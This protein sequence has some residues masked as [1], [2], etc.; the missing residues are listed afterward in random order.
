MESFLSRYRN[1]LILVA[2]LFAQVLGLAVQVRRPADSEHPDRGSVRLIRT[3]AVSAISP[4]EKVLVHSGRLVRGLWTDYV[5]LR[6]VREQNET[7]R[8]QIGR[9]RIEEVRL[10]E[11]AAQA[12]RLQTL[13]DFRSQFITGTLPAQVIG[14]S[15]SRVSRVIY[16]DKGSGDG[17]EKDMAVITPNGIVGKVL[18]AMPTSS[19]VLLINDQSSGVGAILE[20][21]RLHGVIK[22]TADGDVVLQYIMEGEPVQVGETVLTSGGDLIFPKGLPIG[23]VERIDS[24]AAGVFHNIRLRPAADLNRLEEVLVVTE[25][26]RLP[27]EGEVRAADIL[28]ERLPKVPPAEPPSKGNRDKQTASASPAAPSAAAAAPATAPEGVN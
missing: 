17:V 24:D 1:L 12:R 22:G 6:N 27:P 7:L 26:Q 3:W 25:V 2:V 20:H 15:G 21:S 11:D 28:A 18:Q 14:S 8:R 10:R 23:V 9:L 16:L 19:Q 4:F 13:F 5:Y